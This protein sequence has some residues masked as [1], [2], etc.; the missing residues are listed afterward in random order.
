MMKNIFSKLLII[1]IVSISMVNIGC[2]K[3]AGVEKNYFK[4]YINKDILLKQDLRYCGILNLGASLNHDNTFRH[5]LL[6]SSLPISSNT[7]FKALE[8]DGDY[9]SIIYYSSSDSELLPG[10][11]TFDAFGSQDDF[12]INHCLVFCQAPGDYSSGVM[13]V[14]KSGINYIINL[15]F[16]DSVVNIELITSSLYGNYSGVIQN[17][18]VGKK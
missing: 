17:F 9:I 15:E 18:S 14:T 11:Y 8:S 16:Y 5:E 3:E 10:E 12:T 4:I 6:I 7:S 2:K 1:G 13:E